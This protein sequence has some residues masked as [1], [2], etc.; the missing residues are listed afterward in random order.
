MEIFWEFIIKQGVDEVVC[1][2]DQGSWGQILCIKSLTCCNLPR[3]SWRSLGHEALVDQ[4]SPNCIHSWVFMKENP[5]GATQWSSG[6]M[7]AS[8]LWLLRLPFRSMIENSKSSKFLYETNQIPEKEV[9]INISRPANPLS[10]NPRFKN[11]GLDWAT[12]HLG[13]SK[14]QTGKWQETKCLPWPCREHWAS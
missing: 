4:D 14:L 12:G 3:S 8:R 7:T 11:L 1:W 9:R 6:P 10:K 5:V 2:C 13:A